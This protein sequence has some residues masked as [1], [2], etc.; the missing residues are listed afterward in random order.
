MSVL[1]NLKPGDLIAIMFPV[2]E[3]TIA[4]ID[5]VTDHAITIGH[6]RF[7]PQAGVQIVDRAWA[8]PWWL[9][10]LTNALSQE[11]SASQRQWAIENPREERWTL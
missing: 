3:P 8:T 6:C 5:S 9:V 7:N 10:R 4:R 11:I 2:G 1:N